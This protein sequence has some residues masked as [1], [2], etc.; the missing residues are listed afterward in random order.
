MNKRITEYLNT[1]CAQIKSKQNRLSARAELM[2]H[3]H[4]SVDDLKQK[5]MNEEDA[6]KVTLERMGNP[7]EIGSQIS[8]FN[9]TWKIY[10]VTMAGII[11]LMALLIW[12]GVFRKIHLFDITALVFVVL[13]TAAIILI[14]GISRLTK[15]SALARGRSAALYA[16]G[17]GSVIGLVDAL[18][19]IGNLENFG[20]ALSFCITSVLYGLITSAVLTGIGHL[21]RPLEAHE[22]CKILG[23]DYE[24]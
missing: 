10:M 7:S 5:G 24:L 3:I 2:S 13:V 23:W 19:N 17:I 8:A 20:V 22:I 6:V 16:G 9:P 21:C 12:V 1:A 14:G 15:L 18:G 11:L 4:A